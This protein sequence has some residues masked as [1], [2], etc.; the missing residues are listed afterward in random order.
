MV[1]KPDTVSLSF[2]AVNWQR[3]TP[4]EEATLLFVVRGRRILLIHKKRGLGAGKMNGAGGRLQRGE[5][6]RQ[7]AI[8]EFREELGVSPRNVE[9]RGEVHFQMTNGTAI[10]IHVFAATDC[11]GEPRATEEAEPIWTQVDAIPYER[12]WAD[13]RYWMPHLLAGRPFVLRSLFDGETMLG[14]RLVDA[15]DRESPE[16]P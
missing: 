16:A 5:T 10:R 15:P 11:D 4:R 1:Q 14:Y 7:G 13:D 12:M 8:R 3:W 6:P 2:D 9:K